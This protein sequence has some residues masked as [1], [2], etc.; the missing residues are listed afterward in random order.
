MAQA[1][2]T[3]TLW[4]GETAYVDLKGESE[5]PDVARCEKGGVSV[6]PGY[7]EDVAYEMKPG[8]V[9]MRTRP[10]VWR[11]LGVSA[12]GIGDRVRPTACRITA[13]ADVKPGVYDFGSLKVKV[14]DRVL[15]PAREWKYFLDLWQHPW[16]V[17]RYFNVAP[18]SKP[19]FFRMRPVWQTLAECGVKTITVTI[20]DLPWNNQ[21][22][23]AYH[24]MIERVKNADGTWSFNYALFDY[25]VNFAKSCGLGPDIACYTMCPWGYM[26]SWKE[27]KEGNWEPGMAEGLVDRREKLLPGTKEFDEYWSPFLVDFAAHLKKMGWFQD[28]YIAMDER[29]PQDVLAIA[30]L[31]QQRAPGMKIAMAGNRSPSEFEGITIDNY[32]QGLIHLRKKPEFLNELA[33]RRANGYKT[34]FYVCATAAHPNTFMESPDDEGYWLGAYPVMAGF[35]GFLR[36]AANS[37]PKD[38][39]KDASFKTKNW[40]AGDTF[41]VY[42]NGEPSA[43]LLALR[44]GI[45]AAEKMRILK[46]QGP[47]VETAIRD[48]AAPY[49]YKSAVRGEIDFAAFRREVEAFVNGDSPRGSR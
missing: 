31:V 43:R 36:W 19:H 38:P 21:C 44:A 6:A 10:D 16:A 5:K 17:A 34:T 25:Y 41:L 13:A 40:K 30:K 49:G 33:P 37:W 27:C 28:A 29:K 45:V 22:Y 46:G 12:K 11:E 23:D 3:V 42:P 35:D 39:Y 4:R 9:D 2:V 15:P 47:G 20:L 14:L 26:A 8:G 1:D 18:F 48:I 24:S 32:C 7:F